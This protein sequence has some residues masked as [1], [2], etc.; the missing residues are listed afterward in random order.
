[1]KYYFWLVHLRTKFKLDNSKSAQIKQFKANIQKIPNPKK[2]E[3]FNRFWQNS[4]PKV[5]DQYIIF[6]CSFTTIARILRKLELP[7]TFFEKFKII[8]FQKIVTIKEAWLLH[9]CTKFQL[10]ISSRL[11]VIG[12]WKVENRAHAHIHTHTHTHTHTHIQTSAE[13][14]ISNTNVSKFIFFTKT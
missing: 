3:C 5:F 4:I 1:M 14:H 7:Q 6:G 11:W 2:F 9:W 8:K 13:N 10:D 12:V